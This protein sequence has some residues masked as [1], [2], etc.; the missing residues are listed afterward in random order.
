MENLNAYQMLS[1]AAKRRKSLAQGAS[2]GF[3]FTGKTNREAAAALQHSA[4]VRMALRRAANFFNPARN[5]NRRSESGF[6]RLS[7]SRKITIN[8]L[9]VGILRRKRSEGGNNVTGNL[10][11][12]GNGRSGAGNY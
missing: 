1:N 4:F 8:G 10:L 2:P 3:D 6:R 11:R 7:S 5:S 9:A 12:R